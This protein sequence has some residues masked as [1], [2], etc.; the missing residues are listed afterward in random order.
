MEKEP[1]KLNSTKLLT[2]IAQVIRHVFLPPFEKTDKSTSDKEK[3]R[4]KEKGNLKMEMKQSLSK[5]IS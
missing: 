3:E 2:A 4:E 1:Q 5:F